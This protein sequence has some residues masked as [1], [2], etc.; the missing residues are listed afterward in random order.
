MSKK[1]Y[2][3][4]LKDTIRVKFD[5]VEFETKYNEIKESYTFYGFEKYLFF[6]NYYLDRKILLIQKENEDVNS[7]IIKSLRVYSIR[8]DKFS[9]YTDEVVVYISKRIP[10]IKF[11]R[12][13]P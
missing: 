3:R 4:L 2:K 12:F 6:K 11:I 1:M 8:D 9:F 10:P 5:G 7:F 13:K